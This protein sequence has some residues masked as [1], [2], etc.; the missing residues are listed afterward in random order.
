MK[1][2]GIALGVTVALTS[3]PTNPVLRP[4]FAVASVKPSNAQGRAAYGTGNGRG[5][6]K[7]ATLTM[8]IGLAYLSTRSLWQKAGQRSNCLW[9]R[10]HLMILL[11]RHGPEMHR[12]AG[13]C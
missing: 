11:L 5:Y 6:G 2:I 7:N 12:T 4:E 9:I 3:A 13:A 8:L 10:L 1:L